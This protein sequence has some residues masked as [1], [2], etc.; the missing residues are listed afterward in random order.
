MKRKNFF[1][2]FFRGRQKKISRLLSRLTV[3]TE[4][5]DKILYPKK[6]TTSEIYTSSNSNQLK[7]VQICSTYSLKG[8]WK[9]TFV[10][11][12]SFS[13]SNFFASLFSFF[14]KSKAKNP[15]FFNTSCD[16][17]LGWKIKFVLTAYSTPQTRPSPPW[18]SRLVP[19][20]PVGLKSRLYE[21]IFFLLVM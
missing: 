4:H 15:N 11:M 10:F 16:D 2:C 12:T 17:F 13:V 19:G 7:R 9:R 3:E 8:S 1:N 20:V 5:F 18:V 6:Y 21:G 14:G